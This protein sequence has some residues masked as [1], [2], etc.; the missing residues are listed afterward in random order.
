ML[1]PISL[2][3]SYFAVAGIGAGSCFGL[4]K[5]PYKFGYFGFGSFFMLFSLL[6]T[7]LGKDNFFLISAALAFFLASS[8]NIFATLL[9]AASSCWGSATVALF[10]EFFPKVATSSF[11]SVSFCWRPRPSFDFTFGT[12]EAVPGGENLDFSGFSAGSEAGYLA[13]TTGSCG[14]FWPSL[15]MSFSKPSN[16]LPL[17][18]LYTY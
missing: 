8:S 16:L 1:T 7:L 9:S 10:S 15:K 2:L 5:G 18:L 17:S 6:K 11:S 13:S 3:I 14:G 4:I 12:L